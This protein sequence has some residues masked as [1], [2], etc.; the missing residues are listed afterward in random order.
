MKKKSILV[1]DDD[2]EIRKM[3]NLILQDDYKVVDAENGV[4]G[5]E[6][7]KS[8]KPDLI[9]LDLKM[10]KIS[11]FDVC[12]SLKIDPTTREI[13]VIILTASSETKNLVTAFETGADDFI[14]KP[15]HTDELLARV[16][17]KLKSRQSCAILS[18]GDITM[19]LNSMQVFIGKKQLEF[20]VLEFNL[21]RFFV[22]YKN[23]VISRERVLESVWEKIRVS[24]R[25]VDT[26]IVSLRRKISGSNCSLQTVYGAGYKLTEPKPKETRLT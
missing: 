1:I 5:L 12:K 11:G 26:H 25:T 22:T 21:L 7:T 14:E 17:S 8:L 6:L 13:S 2:S 23:S 9:L 18:A 3:L 4:K 10:P 16:S 19:D 15:F 24:D 20:S